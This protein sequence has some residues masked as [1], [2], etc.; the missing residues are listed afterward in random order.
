MSDEDAVRSAD[1]LCA[2]PLVP[3]DQLVL[4]PRLVAVLALFSPAA[5]QFA[6]GNVGGEEKLKRLQQGEAR[7]SPRLAA[8]FP[9]LLR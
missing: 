1:R 5:R 9:E 8:D 4:D 7:E 6:A 2:A 3:G